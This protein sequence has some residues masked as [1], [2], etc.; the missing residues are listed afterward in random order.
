[1]VKK[2]VLEDESGQGKIELGKPLRD[3][4]PVRRSA[5]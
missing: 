2:Q 1:M 5:F 3:I 4:S